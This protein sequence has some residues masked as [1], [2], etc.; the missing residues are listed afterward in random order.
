MTHMTIQLFLAL[1]TI[2]LIS[3]NAS[4]CKVRPTKSLCPM[5]MS[6]DPKNNCCV[7]NGKQPS[8]IPNSNAQAFVPRKIGSLR[9]EKKH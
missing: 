6:L 9:L 5:S 1:F 2:L 8:F 4:V 7:S 3:A